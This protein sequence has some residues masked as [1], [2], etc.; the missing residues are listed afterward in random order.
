MTDISTAL[1]RQRRR[2]TRHRHPGRPGHPHR[3]RPRSCAGR[4]S[5]GSPTTS[6][7]DVALRTLAANGGTAALIAEVDGRMS[8]TMTGRVAALIELPTA[9]WFVTPTGTDGHT[10]GV[11][12][13]AVRFAV[14]LDAIR[15]RRPHAQHRSEPVDP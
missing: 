5:T 14:G 2:R 4:T 12:G 15:A 9:N 1:P 3:D 6:G 8:I 7:S 10:V 13:D 11:P